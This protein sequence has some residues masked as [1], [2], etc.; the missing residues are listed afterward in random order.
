MWM[1]RALKNQPI[2]KR[3]AQFDSKRW[4]FWID[5]VNVS[6]YFDIWSIESWW[7][8]VFFFF[9]D[10]KGREERKEEG[11][12]LY[13][14]VCV[15]IY[16]IYIFR[17]ND[18]LRTGEILRDRREEKGKKKKGKKKRSII[19]DGERSFNS[20]L[21]CSIQFFSPFRWFSRFAV[22][23]GFCSHSNRLDLVLIVVTS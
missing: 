17:K 2:W 11:S 23:G 20:G 3:W 9:V 12:S 21:T 13:V 19:Y 15:F 7:R 1:N 18:R 16:K 6:S 10:L 4:G 14:C 5:D 22:L 8:V